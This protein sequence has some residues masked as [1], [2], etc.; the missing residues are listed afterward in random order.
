MSVGGDSLWGLAVCPQLLRAV[1]RV[2]SAAAV[3]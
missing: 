1:G 3:T 2:S